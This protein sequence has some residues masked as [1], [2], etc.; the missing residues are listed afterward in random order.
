VITTTDT[1]PAIADLFEAVFSVQTAVAA[2]SL[3]NIAA[4]RNS[5][6]CG[7]CPKAI[8]GELKPMVRAI[9]KMQMFATLDKANPDTGLGG[10]QAY[11]RSS[12]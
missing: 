2:A 12:D 6:F 8:S 4:T 5:V 1:H 9:M 11:D 3:C 10:S 7:V